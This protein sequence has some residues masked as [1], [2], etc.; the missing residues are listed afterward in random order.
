MHEPRQ[1]LSIDASAVDQSLG[2]MTVFLCRSLAN[3]RAVQ[4]SGYD[5]A[6]GFYFSLPVPAH[7]VTRTIVQCE[8]RLSGA[9]GLAA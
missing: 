3:L 4:S 6:Q 8:K 9:N 5:E 7:A 1:R 2:V